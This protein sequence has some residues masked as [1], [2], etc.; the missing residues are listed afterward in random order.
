[1]TRKGKKEVSTAGS[2]IIILGPSAGITMESE[3]GSIGGIDVSDILGKEDL[4]KRDKQVRILERLGAKKTRKKYATV[5]ERKKA[6]A[7][8]QKAAREENRKVLEQYGIAPKKRVTLSDSER[9][10]HQKK[11]R[12]ERARREKSLLRDVMKANPT[13]ARQYGFDP[14]RVRFKPPTI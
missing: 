1:M 11:Y 7:D 9:R 4:S 3:T 6:Q 2:D 8:R 12:R 10:E 5:A 13:L 14:T